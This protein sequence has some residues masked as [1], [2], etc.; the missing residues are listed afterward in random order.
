MVQPLWEK[1]W[2]FLI[3]LCI[4]I[5]MT[6]IDPGE[7]KKYFHKKTHKTIQSS[8]IHYS[9]KLETIQVSNNRMDKLLYIYTMEYYVAKKKKRAN[10]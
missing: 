1:I 6:Q 9:Q 7:M 10:F 8:F 3:K 5:P 2:Q 4:N